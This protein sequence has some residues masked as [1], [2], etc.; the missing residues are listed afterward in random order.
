MPRLPPRHVLVAVRVHERNAADARQELREHERQAGRAERELIILCRVR[1]GLPVVII[2]IR[3]RGRLEVV[4]KAGA[5]SPAEGR[6][7][8]LQER[9]ESFSLLFLMFSSI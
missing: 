7:L 2:F 3:R 6:Y 5:L 9:K 1:F 8:R 4:E